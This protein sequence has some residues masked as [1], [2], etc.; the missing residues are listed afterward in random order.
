MTIKARGTHFEYRVKHFME[1]HGLTVIRS[2]GSHSV[3]D[4]VGLSPYGVLLVQCKIGGFSSVSKKERAGLIELT[5]LSPYYSALIVCRER[6]TNRLLVWAWSSK[7]LAWIKYETYFAK[8]A[9]PW[10]RL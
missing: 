2:A 7:L 8:G 10:R 6:V 3:V 9:T 1:G 4:L 5:E